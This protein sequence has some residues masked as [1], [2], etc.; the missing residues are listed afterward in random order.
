MVVGH[1][2]VNVLNEV[3]EPFTEAEVLGVG[4]EK[5]KEKLKRGGSNGIEEVVLQDK[6]RK[7]RKEYSGSEEEK[8]SSRSEEVDLQDRKMKCEVWT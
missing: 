3:L 4:G 7:F 5:S 8:N 2:K 1:K 6:R